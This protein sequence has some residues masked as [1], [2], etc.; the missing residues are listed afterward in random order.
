[1]YNEIIEIITGAIDRNTA[2]NGVNYELSCEQIKKQV[3]K[4]FGSLWHCII[5]EGFS[6]D[7]TA[8]VCFMCTQF[9]E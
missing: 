8:Q 5:G 7:V 9:M 2:V 1:M 6:F 4:R 3:D